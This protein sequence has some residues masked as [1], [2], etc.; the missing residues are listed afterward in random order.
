[1][2][3]VDNCL[4]KWTIAEENMKLGGDMRRLGGEVAA[5]H[6]QSCRKGEIRGKIPTLE[7]VYE[8]CR[9]QEVMRKKLWEHYYGEVLRSCYLF[10][11]KS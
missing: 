6:G 1:M 11:A 10:D 7:A 9:I 4:I 5:Y 2:L 8:G 3:D